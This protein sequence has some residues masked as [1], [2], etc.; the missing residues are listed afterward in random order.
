MFKN[1][2]SEMYFHSLFVGK[3]PSTLGS[4]VTL[5]TIYKG[6]FSHGHNALWC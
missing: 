1:A 5:W 4:R 3:T 6:W 2:Q